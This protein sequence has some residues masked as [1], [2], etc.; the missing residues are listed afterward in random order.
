[1]SIQPAWQQ[2]FGF[3]GLPIVVEPSRAALPGDA[4]LFPLRQFDEQI[5]LTR[6][7]AAALSPDGAQGVVEMSL[8]QYLSFVSPTT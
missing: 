7:F 4:G 5:T 8:S 3:F 2:T 1:M 6:A